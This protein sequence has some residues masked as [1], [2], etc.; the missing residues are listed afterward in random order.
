MSRLI[1]HLFCGYKS[2]ELKTVTLFLPDK[3][4]Q[5]ETKLPLLVMHDGHNLFFPEQSAF[6]ETWK[7]RECLEELERTTGKKLILAGIACPSISRYDDY[8]P[9][10]ADCDP[11]LLGFVSTKPVGGQGDLYLDWINQKVI[12]NICANY[13]ID[14]AR[15]FMAG[16]SMGGFISLYAGYRS[17]NIYRKV[18]AFSPALWFAE[19]AMTEFIEK[20]HNPKIGIYLDVGTNESSNPQVPNFPEIYLSGARRLYQLLKRL[21]TD[22]LLYLEEVGGIHAETAWARRFPKFC[23]WLLDSPDR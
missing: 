11:Q 8:S 10:L 18:G 4:D 16:S 20:S 19:K 21:G 13:P 9:F 7:V 15:I 14:P 1:T 22:N 5:P 6:G 23:Q 17:P 2:G 3:P 12:P